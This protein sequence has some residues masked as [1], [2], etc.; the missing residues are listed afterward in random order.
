MMWLISEMGNPDSQ[1]RAYLDILPGS[2]PNHP[3]SWTDEEL[4]ETAGTGLDNTSKSIK[5]L[6]QKVFEHLSEKLVQANPSLF[7]GWSFEK[8][9]WAFQTVNSRSWTVTNENNEKESVLVPLADM[10]NHAPGAGL[11]G[12]SYDK[13]YFMINATK[14]YATGDQVFDNYGAKSNF[15]LLSTYGFVLEDNAYDYMTLQFSLKPSNLV[16]TIVE[17]LLKAVDPTYN[18]I[19]IRTNKVPVELLRVFRLSVMEFSELEY[20]NQALQGKAVSL[21]N[22][23]RAFRSAIKALTSMLQAFP[24]SLQQD[25]ELLESAESMSTNQRN[26]VVLRK[27]QKEIL[28]NNIVVL[29]KMWENILLSGEL[30][31]SV[32]V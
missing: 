30:F 4:A 2:Y 9:V 11:G 7:P 8:F 21:T 26:A 25:K 12:L 14:D 18:N 15:D 10:L 17:P 6:L 1:Y 23:M 24:T 29:G 28:V 20:V 16:H 22:E 31:G 5:Q 3:L 13:T 27:T 19:K 32:A